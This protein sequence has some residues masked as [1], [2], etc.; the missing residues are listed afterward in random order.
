MSVLVCGFGGPQRCHQKC[1]V[2]EMSFCGLCVWHCVGSWRFLVVLGRSRPCVLGL[3]GLTVKCFVVGGFGGGLQI[4]SQKCVAHWAEWAP[5]SIKLHQKSIQNQLKWCPGALL[6]G[7]SKQAGNNVYSW[8]VFCDSWDA[9]CRAYWR[10]LADFRCH[11]GPDWTPM[12]CK[13]ELFGTRISKNR[14]IEI[15]G[16]VPETHWNFDQRLRGK[17]EILRVPNLPRCFIY[18]HLGGFSRLL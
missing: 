10:N 3:E 12:A 6:G 11:L 14:K 7:S 9:F 16:K 17:S 1:T 5:E 2:C 8:D 15:Q 13:S 4:C 18:K